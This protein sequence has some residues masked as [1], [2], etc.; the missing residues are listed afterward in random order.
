MPGR[1]LVGSPPGEVAP[2]AID[3]LRIDG[4]LFF[5]ATDHVRDRLDAARADFPSARHVLLI[6]SG[7]NFIDVAGA[8]L[9][10]EF[11]NALRQQGATLWLTHLRESVRE[12]LERGG[13]MQAIGPGHAFDIDDDALRAIRAE[14]EAQSQPQPPPD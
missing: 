11:A 5:G 7:V 4:S 14:I 1:H 10:A 13:Y 3:M 12:V 2:D 6:L 8:G 9:L